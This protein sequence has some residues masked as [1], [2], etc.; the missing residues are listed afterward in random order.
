MC[1]LFCVLVLFATFGFHARGGSLHGRYIIPIVWVGIFAMSV[2]LR[3]GFGVGA[4]VA[5]LAAAVISHLLV[6]DTYVSIAFEHLP[7][8]GLNLIEAAK[9]TGLEHPT[10][11]L[12]AALCGLAL[13]V[14]ACAAQIFSD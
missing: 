3:R 10:P 1:L 13:G 6:L 12:V 11:L 8:N 4:L 14:A 5:A 2:G 9:Q 7:R